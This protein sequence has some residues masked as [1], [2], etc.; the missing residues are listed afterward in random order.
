M[1][2]KHYRVICS[3]RYYCSSRINTTINR[4]CWSTFCHRRCRCWGCKHHA[5]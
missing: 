2:T 5:I 4:R 3:A 1:E